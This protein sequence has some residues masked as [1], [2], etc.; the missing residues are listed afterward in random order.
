MKP[1][2]TLD[3]KKYVT[4]E[5]HRLYE[6]YTVG[7]LRDLL[8]ARGVKLNAGY[9]AKEQL[10]LK[11]AE[12]SPMEMQKVAQ[13]TND[14]KDR[15]IDVKWRARMLASGREIQRMLDTTTEVVSRLRERPR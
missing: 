3:D 1:A 13:L 5:V 11:A 2:Q 14:L 12:S 15:G 4:R 8:V 7:E 9:T 10:V 6:V